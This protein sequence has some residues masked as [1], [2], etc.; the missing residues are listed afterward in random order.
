MELESSW[1]KQRDLLGTGFDTSKLCFV[2]VVEIAQVVLILCV[3]ASLFLFV[4]HDFKELFAI[5]LFALIINRR[6]LAQSVVEALDLLAGDCIDVY[7]VVIKVRGFEIV[8]MD[9]LMGCAYAVYASY[10]LHKARGIVGGIIIYDDI[11]F[12]E[13]YALLLGHRW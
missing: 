4:L 13:I 5:K 3:F 10:A 9:L 2:V 11:G 8:N 1:I 7:N 12:M 6:I